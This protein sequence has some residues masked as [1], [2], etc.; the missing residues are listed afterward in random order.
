MS[1]RTINRILISTIGFLCIIICI[2]IVLIISRPHQ[3][4]T[5]GSSTASMEEIPAT[6]IIHFG[7]VITEDTASV[8]ESSAPPSTEEQEAVLYA[9]TTSLVNIRASNSTDAAVVETVS[10]NTI[11]Q[12]LEIQQDGWTKILYEGQEAYISSAYIILIH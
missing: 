8:E 11:L 5:Q 3:I 12:V 4:I 6:E 9:R 7:N 10:E 2:L 1:N